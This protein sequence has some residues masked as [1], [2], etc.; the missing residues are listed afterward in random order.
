MSAPHARR[1]LRRAVSSSIVLLVVLYVFLYAPILYVIYTSF[2]EDIVW[3]FP[4]SFT[5]QAYADV[6]DSSLYADALRNS[7]LIGLGSGLLVDAA[8][9]G[10]RDRPP[11]LP[12]ARGDGWCCSSSSRRSSWPN[13]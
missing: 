7:I 1:A 6:F 5:L 2:A 3:P 13:C 12:V 9:D 11:A 4:P 10:R 8:R